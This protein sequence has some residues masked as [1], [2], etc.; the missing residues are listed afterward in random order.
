MNRLFRRQVS[1][2]DVISNHSPN[3]PLSFQNKTQRLLDSILTRNVEAMSADEL[4]PEVGTM[5]GSDLGALVN[6]NSIVKRINKVSMFNDIVITPLISENSLKE[7]NIVRI[8]LTGSIYNDS[9]SS[10]NFKVRIFSGTGGDVEIGSVITLAATSSGIRKNWQYTVEISQAPSLGC[11]LRVIEKLEID[12]TSTRSQT[13]TDTSG[14]YAD[15][16]EIDGLYIM[17]LTN[18]AAAKVTVYTDNF[19]LSFIDG[20]SD[21][22]KISYAQ[23]GTSGTIQSDVPTTATDTLITVGESNAGASQIRRAFIKPPSGFLAS[24]PPDAI[25]DFVYIF[26]RYNSDLSSNASVMDAYRVLRNWVSPTWNQYSSGNNWA[27]AGC[28]DSTNDY[29]GSVVWGSMSLASSETINNWKSLV[30]DPAEFQKIIDKTYTD[31]YGLMLRK[32]T[33]T[34]TSNNADRFYSYSAAT[35]EDR[36]IWYIGYHTE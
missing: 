34:T 12:A 18:A 16:N 32:E 28:G 27:T 5:Y 14:T 20:I 33:E 4:A 35:V 22:D 8:T 36:P 7:D 1:P 30:L 23:S 17:V 2:L 6:G 10:T 26:L 11:D 13:Q 21:P 15:L 19:I 25:I 31:F 24:I 29:D 9:G 3:N